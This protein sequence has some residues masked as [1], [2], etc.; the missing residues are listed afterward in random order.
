MQPTGPLFL[1]EFRNSDTANPDLSFTANQH[2]FASHS[3]CKGQILRIF[4][5]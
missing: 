4:A 5:I 3:A 2:E 1:Q